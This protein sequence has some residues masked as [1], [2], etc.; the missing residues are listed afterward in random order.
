MI[1]HNIKLTF[2]SLLKNKVYSTLIIGGFSIGFAA[3]ILIGLFYFTEKNVNKGFVNHKQIYRLYDVK[4]N[5][6]NINY[7]LN[8]L[9]ASDYSE[10]V[11]TCPMEYF[12]KA[13]FTAK[14]EQANA[15][16]SLNN[17]ISTNNNFFKIFSVEV[18]QSLSN[19][20]FEGKESFV[21]TE[22]VA[23]RLYKDGNAVGKILTIDNFFISLSGKVTAVIKDLPENSSF[24]AEIILNSDFEK[25][26]LSS[27]NVNGNRFN[28]TNQYIELNDGVNIENFTSRLNSTINLSQFDIGQLAL[29]NLDDFY[30]STLTMKD[31]HFKGNPGLLNIF[32]AIAI[33]ILLLSSINYLNYTVSMQYSKLKTIGINKT[34]GAG[35]RQLVAYSFTEVSLGIIISVILSLI[36]TAI[37]LPS[38]DIM[39]GKAIHFDRVLLFQFLPVLVV[40]ILFLIMVN[41]LAPFY[42]LSRFK[43]SDFLSGTRKRKKKQIWKQALLS[44]QLTASI[45]LIATVLC[46]FKQLNFVKQADLGFDKELLVRIDIPYYFKNLDALRLEIDKLPFVSKT[47]FSN[48]CPGQINL[49]MGSNTGEDDFNVDCILVG[50]EYLETMGIELLNGRNFLSGD[51][52]K[53]CLLNEAA[54]KR[55]GFESIDGQRFNNGREGGYEIIGITKNFHISSFYNAIVPVA[56][57]YNPDIARSIISIKLMPG[58]IGQY[59]DKIKDVWKELLPYEVMTYF[60]YDDQ[61]QAMYSKEDKMAKA[62]TFFSFIAIILTCMGILAQIFLISLYRTKEIGIRKVNGARVAE[63][64]LLLNKNFII[65]VMIAFVIATP[66]A[67]YTMYK[68]LQSFAFKTDLSWWIFATAGLIAMVI[69]IATVSWQSWR[70]ATRNPV[71]ALRYE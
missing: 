24:K 34:N 22:S 8:S 69:V 58:N 19:Q 30:L 5:K 35:W 25:F 37:L 12:T 36:F 3:C 39:F 4:K 7:N 51:V 68:W 10:I 65:S 62:I 18:I 32:L 66:I 27:T 6:C 48:G 38:S 44:F 63:I 31:A 70:A 59:I 46:V 54:M 45:A 52:D 20:P 26:R 2:R 53:V 49:R 21:I 64:M 43:V 13:P 47:A 56:L 42:L 23:R 71:E 29:Q 55:Y 28:L 15:S 14:D 17:V 16:T 60:F 33:L 61:F 1:R 50:D 40:T 67:F 57:I 11:N 41:S 9:L